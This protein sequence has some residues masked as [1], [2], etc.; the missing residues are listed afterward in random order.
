MISNLKPY[1]RY[2]PSGVDWLGDVPEHWE[3][4]RLKRICFFIYGDSLPVELRRV[5]NISV[6]G[7]NGPVGYHDAAN[8]LAPCIIVGRKGSFGK[9]R[10]SKKPVFAIDTTYY[11]DK[12][13]TSNNLNWLYYALSW[14]RLDGASRDSAVPG[15]DREEAYARILPLPPH[16]EQKYINNFLNVIS[17]KINRFIRKRRR[18]IEL[19]NEY[20]QAIINQYV[21]GKIDPRTGKPYPRYKPSGVDWLGDVPEHWDIKKLKQITRFQNGFAFKPS[22]WEH[23]GVPIIRIQNLNGSRNFNYTKRT[24]IPSIFLVK[25]GDLLFSWSGNR[26]TSFGS[27]IWDRDFPGYLNQHIF[28]LHG[29][30]CNKTYFVFLLRSVTRYIED[31]K[32]HGI[33]GLVHVTK[34]EL[35]STT[36]ALPPI[37]EQE[38]IAERLMG[39]SNRIDAA[40][41]SA[42]REIALIREF[43][44]RLIA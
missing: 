38:E 28:K 23:E 4:K 11:I 9:V 15:L 21:T 25:P 26:G 39:E 18:L 6:Y 36:V 27:Y 22:D 8:T 20:K 35:G 17:S 37:L 3:V 2:K 31:E 44:T 19:L 40:L 29:Y 13:Y 41:A 30:T 16:D 33:I 32:T 14:L 34:P 12:R 7:S 5:G 42:Q 10:Y 24:D 1:P 43:R